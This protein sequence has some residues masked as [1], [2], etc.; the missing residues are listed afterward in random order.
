MDT[1]AAGAEF[2]AVEDKVVAFRAHFP[3]RGFEL[4]E[5]FVDDPG[6]GMLR[7]DPGFVIL[8]P[9][10]ERKAGD[11]EKFPLGAI[12]LFKRF[13]EIQAQLTGDERGGFGP[14]DLLSGADGDNE[15]SGFCTALVGE[16]FYIFRAD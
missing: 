15:I 11:P 7:A 10:K 14:L 4:F 16:F 5:I 13:A 1:N 6:E 8:A 9:F 2:V 12:D 3:R